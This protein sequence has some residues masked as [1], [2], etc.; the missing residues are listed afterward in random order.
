MIPDKC[1]QSILIPSLLLIVSFGL[2]FLVASNE[3]QPASS[4]AK[5]NY[6]NFKQFSRNTERAEYEDYAKKEGSKVKDAAQFQ[7][8]K[9]HVMSMYKEVKV[10]NS[11]VLG[12][13]HIDCVDVKTQPGLNRDGKRLTLEKPPAPNIAAEEKDNAPASK[14]VEPMLSKRKKDPHGNVQ[15][16]EPGSIPMRRITLDELVRYETLADFFNK[17]GK[18]GEKGNP[19]PPTQ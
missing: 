9:D 3:A 14:S 2:L 6:V 17:Y 15:F 12:P 8:M 4:G 1:P 19:E 13:D 7:R 11:F 16:C 5:M 18:A 10:R